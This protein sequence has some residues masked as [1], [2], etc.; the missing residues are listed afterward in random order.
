M[1]ITTLENK[2]PKDDKIE[3]PCLLRHVIDDMVILATNPAKGVVLQ[4]GQSENFKIG[5][6]Y[7]FFSF[8]CSFSK[9]PSWEY[10]RGTITLEQ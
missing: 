3:F 4:V 1:K 9:S 8:D 10:Y 6:Y 5:G 7:H 2:T